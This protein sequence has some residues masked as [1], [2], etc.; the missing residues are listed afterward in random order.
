MAE[1]ETAE[2]VAAAAGGIVVAVRAD[3]ALAAEV[4]GIAVTANS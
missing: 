3:A 4:V 1:V 2:A